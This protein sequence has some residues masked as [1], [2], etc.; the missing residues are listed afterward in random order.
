MQDLKIDGVGTISSG[1]YGT[2]QVDGI[3]KCTGD[4]KAEKIS[5]DG[6]LRCTGNLEA[7]LLDCDGLVRVQGDI[8]VGLMDIDGLLRVSG[9]TRIEADEIRCDGMIK[10]EGE[11]SADS[12]K[13]DG[14][15]N[16]REIVGETIR[17]NSGIPWFL[18]LFW[19]K[20]SRIPLIEATTVELRNVLADSVNGKDI[21]IGRGCRIGRLDCSGT[22][23]VARSARVKEITGE[24][25]LRGA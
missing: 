8:K 18:R 2:L 17:I 11:V 6:I 16:A 5:V 13:A 24:Y 4:I 15:I 21:T 1:E 12:I 25:T 19:K 9:G 14:F 23:F 20:R 22:L 10:L 7:G 3:G